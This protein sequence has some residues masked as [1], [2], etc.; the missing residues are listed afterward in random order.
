MR[1]G[2]AVE[3]Q[4]SPGEEHSRIGEVV[5]LWGEAAG[6]GG[7]RMLGRFQRYYRPQVGGV[8]GGVGRRGVWLVTVG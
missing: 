7:E 6:G 2:G 4:P 5:A 8:G 3:L 1:L